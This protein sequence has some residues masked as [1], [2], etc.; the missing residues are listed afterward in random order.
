MFR[1]KLYNEVAEETGQNTVV[2]KAPGN[3][4]SLRKLLFNRSSPL[5]LN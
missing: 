4:F 3:V 5:I 1:N 2:W